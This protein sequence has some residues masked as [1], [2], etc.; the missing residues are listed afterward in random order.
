MSENKEMKI[1]ISDEALEEIEGMMTPEEA[2][3]FMDELKKAVED[4]SFFANSQPVDLEELKTEDPELYELLV[5]RLGELP[6]DE[7]ETII[8][9]KRTLN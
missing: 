4:G 3:Q 8:E 6:V 9:P 7:E 1:I 5:E 2:Q